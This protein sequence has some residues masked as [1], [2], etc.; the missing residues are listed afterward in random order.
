L[1]L[2]LILVTVG[3]SS[4]KGFFVDPTLKDITV[5][6]VTPSVSAGSTQ[7]MTATGTYTDGST[8]DI[9]SSVSWSSDD[10]AVFAVSSTGLVKGNEPGS[11][12]VTA[13]SAT[14]G[15]STTVTVTV[16]NLSSIAIT[17]TDSSISSG[18]TQQYKAIGTLNDGT[19]V[20]I[21]DSVTWSSSNTSVATIGNTGLATAQSNGTTY[22]VATSGSI[23]SNTATLN[24]RQ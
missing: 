6:P 13:T 12:S 4:C 9:T 21:T 7:Q 14:I 16:A 5:T 1:S 2:S 15:G 20:N 22:I 10:S 18:G 11:G 19:Q 23:T 17:P 3:L 8:K 24:I